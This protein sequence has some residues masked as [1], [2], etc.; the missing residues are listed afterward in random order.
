MMKQVAKKLGKK[1]REVTYVG[2]HVRRTD[3]VQFLDW[4]HHDEELT[5]EFYLD[6]MDYFREDYD[7]PAFLVVSDDMKWAKDN[8]KSAGEEHGDVFF[9]GKGNEEEDSVAFDFTTMVQSN[10]TIISRGTFSSWSAVLNGGEYYGE[11][12]AI[13]PDDLLY[14]NK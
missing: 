7:S 14:A 3:S 8:L 4:A 12:G 1:A 5:P 2:V 6:A 10:H 11:Y 13:V 9:V